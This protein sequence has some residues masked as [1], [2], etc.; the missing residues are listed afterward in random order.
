MRPSDPVAFAETVV[1]KP[2]GSR[3]VTIRRIS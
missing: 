1:T 3:H 2:D